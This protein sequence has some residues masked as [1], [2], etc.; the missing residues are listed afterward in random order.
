MHFA[1]KALELPDGGSRARQPQR[2]GG[3]SCQGVVMIT[4]QHKPLA[5]FRRHLQWPLNDRKKTFQNNTGTEPKG[6][7]SPSSRSPEG[8]WGETCLHPLFV[9]S[10]AANHW[11][12]PCLNLFRL[13][14][15]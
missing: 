10:T 12:L 8:V 1:G 13:S 11:A 14:P 15:K 9:G 6:S 2:P 7:E 5:S 4:W 3:L